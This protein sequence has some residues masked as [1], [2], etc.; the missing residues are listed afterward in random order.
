MSNQTFGDWSAWS[1]PFTEL[2][3]INQEASE[4]VIRECIAYYSE[5]TGIAIKCM[6]TLPRVTSPEDYLSTQMKIWSQQGEKMMEFAQ[7]VFQIYQDTLREHFQ[8]TEAKVNNVVRTTTK[9]RR[10]QADEAA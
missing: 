1:T 2:Q 7:N 6:Q 10:P 9:V 4:K 5:S 3:K 8:W